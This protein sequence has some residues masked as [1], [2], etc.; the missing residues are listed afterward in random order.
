MW[1]VLFLSSSQFSR[2]QD[3]RLQI[4]LHWPT[5]IRC[6]LWGRISVK[7]V[8]ISCHN[9]DVVMFVY[10][11]GYCDTK[12]SNIAVCFARQRNNVFKGCWL[13]CSRWI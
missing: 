13:R 3:S 4:L 7:T 9:I 8:L 11:C 12:M 10:G 5:T 6:R 2:P 1:H